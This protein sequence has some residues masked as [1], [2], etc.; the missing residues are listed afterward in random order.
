MMNK[1]HRQILAMGMFGAM[2]IASMVAASSVLAN[3]QNPPTS[4]T[5]ST[6]N[7]KEFAGMNNPS[8]L[9][10]V[11]P[12]AVTMSVPDIEAGIKWY[13][14][15]LGFKVVKRKSYPEF[16]TSLV[17]MALNG[18]NVE[19]IQDGNAKPTPL[20]PDPPAHTSTYGITQFQFRT[21]DLA[22][23]KK[24]LIAK[25]IPIV[26]EFENQELGAKFLVIRDLNGNLI[27]FLQPL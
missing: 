3:T 24:E 11:L 5:T 4:K 16:Q 13:T 26:W 12:H 18:Y 17:F 8:A 20:R 25:Q 14:E 6:S 7:N 15:K 9:S 22:A 21:T 2:G 1:M 27:F 19:L 23:V 10:Q